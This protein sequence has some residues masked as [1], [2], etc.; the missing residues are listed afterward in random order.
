M[1]F[2]L[3]E[4]VT[5]KKMFKQQLVKSRIEKCSRLNAVGL[6]AYPSAA[7]LNRVDAITSV[8]IFTRLGKANS[9]D[10]RQRENYTISGRVKLLRKQGKS[11]F[12]QVQDITGTVQAFFSLDTLGDNYPVFKNM[13]DIGDFVIL[14]GNAFYTQKDE[15]TMNVKEI[16]ISSKCLHPLPEKHAGLQDPELRARKRYLDLIMNTDSQQRLID[17]ARII[18]SIRM[19]LVKDDFV[20]VETPILNP[21]AGG[22]NAKPFVTYHNALG[23][24]RFLRIAPELYLKRLI[25]GGLPKVFELGKQFRNEGVDS[26]HNPEF[27]SLEF[28]QTYATYTDLMTQI[29]TMFRDA[30][31]KGSDAY[32]IPFGDE[33]IDF[34][35]WSVFTFRDALTKIGQV[36]FEILDSKDE[37]VSY[38]HD[39]YQEEVS[40]DLVKGKLW[41]KLFDL[42]VESKLIDPTFI[43]DYPA[44]ISP[45]ARRKS[46]DPE[47]VERF[48]LFIGGFELANGFNELNDPIDQ[49]E[50]FKE[51]VASKDSDDEAMFMDKDFVEAL[52][53][54]MPPTAGAGI[55][56]DRLV[57]LLTNSTTIRDVIAFPAM[58]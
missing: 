39:F 1:L 41:E 40:L 34:D 5:M 55:G 22:A 43:I 27:T 20:E 31:S 9:E 51:Q 26:T 56:I 4:G 49:Y 13:L 36:P 2:I 46:D 18:Q 28:Y 3:K 38:M 24:E 45:L 17:R 32:L 14:H 23:V 42:T 52:M 58:K 47:L 6:S 48:E 29:E 8:E 30:V 7:E 50:R 10:A 53:F 25:V 21:I 37:M 33:M 11:G 54:A 19:S 16:Q 12:L 35:S 57:M 44:D 15:F